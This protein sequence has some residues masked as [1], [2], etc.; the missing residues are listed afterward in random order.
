[1]GDFRTRISIYDLKRNESSSWDEDATLVAS[2]G[3]AF[4]NSMVNGN[5]VG[6][7]GHNHSPAAPVGPVFSAERIAFQYEHNYWRLPVGLDEG[8]IVHTSEDRRELIFRE[9]DG[10]FSQFS[11]SGGLTSSLEERRMRVSESKL[12]QRLR[13]ILFRK[14]CAKCTIM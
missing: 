13:Q 8:A 1:V 5:G 9:Y 6:V 12:C 11:R 14:L 7:S 4:N 10:F 2:N 3:S